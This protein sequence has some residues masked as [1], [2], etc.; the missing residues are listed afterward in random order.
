[1]THITPVGETQ[2]RTAAALFPL[3]FILIH[4]LSI[5]QSRGRKKLLVSD[6]KAAV[7]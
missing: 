1:M 7:L 6:E 4:K 2:A 3:I 5:V